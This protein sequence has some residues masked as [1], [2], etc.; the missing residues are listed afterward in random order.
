MSSLHSLSNHQLIEAYQDAIKM[1]LD[2]EFINL[3]EEELKDRNITI[4][5]IKAISV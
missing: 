3:L 4:H 5:S 1:E 2:A